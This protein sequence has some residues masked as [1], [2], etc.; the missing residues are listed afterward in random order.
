MMTLLALDKNERYTLVVDPAIA[1]ETIGDLYK[2]YS[3]HIDANDNVIIIKVKNKDKKSLHISK[4]A[5]VLI[6]KY[7]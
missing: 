5:R 2:A 7:I 3:L 4:R 1:L 6:E